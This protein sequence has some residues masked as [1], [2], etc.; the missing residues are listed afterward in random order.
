MNRW[1]KLL[2][3]SVSI[4]GTFFAGLAIIQ[5]CSDEPDPYDYYTS[6]FNPNIQ[7]KKDFGSFYFTN[8]SFLYDDTAPASEATINAK[9]WAAYL[10]SSVKPADAEKVLYHLDSV[11]NVRLDQHLAGEGTPLA[12]S[13]AGNTFVNALTQPNN[14]PALQYY[15]FA[16]SVE[17]LA[18]TRFDLWDP[19]PIDTAALDTA[20]Q[21]ALTYAQTANNDF[22]KLR[23][24]YQA[25]R[26]MH[27]AKNFEGANGVYEQHIAKLPSQSHVKGWALAL[28]AGEER[29]LGDTVKAAYLFSKVFANYPERRIQA[30]KDYQFTN[31]E[32][33][34]ILKLAQNNQDK[35]TL[36]AINGF[37]N[38]EI[39]TEDMEEVYS[40]DPRS[41][42][43]GVLLVRE[44]NKLEEY[45]LTPALENNN[46]ATYSA[47]STM[48]KAAQSGQSKTAIWPLAIGIVLIAAGIGIYFIMRKKQQSTAKSNTPLWSAAAL[49]VIGVM[50]LGWYAFARSK[51]HQPNTAQ[52]MPQGSFFVS[53]P[54]SVKAKYDAHIEKLRSFCTKL[55]GDDQYP[56]PQIGTLANAY[57]YFIQNK[58]D[59]GMQEIEK[60]DKQQLNEGMDSQKQIIKLL[61]T[62]Q[63]LKKL[64]NVNEQSLLP[65][66]QWLNKKATANS[67]KK[68]DYYAE[69]A[70]DVKT[71]AITQR[72]FYDHVLAPAYLRQG[73]TAKAAIALLKSQN[74]NQI[75][76]SYS[77][78]SVMSLPDFWYKFLHSSH[79]TQIVSWKQHKP[80]DAYTA[81]LTS[82]LQPV[83]NDDL[84]ELLG[85]NYLRE[86]RY[87]Q[88]VQTFKQV[89]NKKLLATAVSD[90]YN[91]N[92]VQGNPFASQVNDYPKNFSGEK[93]DKLK[94]AQ[95]MA[96]LQN[97]LKA[98]PKD[99]AACFQFANGLYS[100]SNYGNSWPMISY[101]WSSMDYGRKSIYDYDADYVQASL[102]EQYYL[103]AREA[104]SDPEMKA[105]CT[106]MAAKCAQ[107]QYVQPGYSDYADY[108]AYDKKQKEYNEQLKENKYFDELK[109]Y[110]NTKFYA[111]AVGECTYLY[112]F[113]NKRK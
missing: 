31:A 25:Q 82:A 51:N 107:K 72:N 93:Y 14:Q 87:D 64:D 95:K 83:K 55:A 37:G 105:K 41:V 61:L 39:G 113:M 59:D 43:T 77:Y 32:F 8:Y 60:L 56:E 73:D 101:E 78:Y 15:Q 110:K 108:K 94:F 65:A 1:K 45:Y 44:I 10:G 33:N 109:A 68:G 4:I 18:N 88:A 79:L 84:Y 102:A 58:P 2:L 70:D 9:E 106:F 62:S 96:A 90:Y 17:P 40:N 27:Y 5:A 24:F 35:A 67:K 92:A 49:I 28:K 20:G 29:K 66:L 36:H 26:L 85:T 111:Q 47:K 21:Q 38:S 52:A 12:D 42:M 22:L 7:G 74:S 91:D 30:Y 112:D 75:A 48:F 80:A 34:D 53:L 97:Q 89:K 104:S 54:D 98:N 46:D 99:A 86:H 81:F 100:T 23:Y 76:G 71:Y 50:G 16:R 103:K 6:F 11:S 3:Y 19:E 57:L 63:Q 69:S 13:I